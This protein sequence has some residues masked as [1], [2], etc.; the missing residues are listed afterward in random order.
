MMRSIAVAVNRAH[1]RINTRPLVRFRRHGATETSLTCLL[2]RSLMCCEEPRMKRT[3]LMSGAVTVML[4]AAPFAIADN[5]ISISADPVQI[6]QGEVD[7]G[8]LIGQ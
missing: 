8:K 5:S 1:S 2:V 3:L 6:A 4:G 7:A